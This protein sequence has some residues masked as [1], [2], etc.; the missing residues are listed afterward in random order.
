M[1]SFPK[2]T[3]AAQKVLSFLLQI[4]YVRTKPN[5]YEVEIP[6]ASTLNSRSEM[7]YKTTTK[8]AV[9]QFRVL[10]FPR[11]KMFALTTN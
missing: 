4:P 1:S 8:T 5:R 2:F 9:I 11:I 10:S 6:K 7:S 3:A